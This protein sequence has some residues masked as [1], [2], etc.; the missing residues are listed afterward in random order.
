MPAGGAGVAAAVVSDG[1]LSGDKGN[2]RGGD[3]AVL[4][5][6]ASAE[7]AD[8]DGRDANPASQPSIKLVGR[9]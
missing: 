5:S 8:T 1:R 2:G 4:R 7:G 6:Q 9:F 3:G